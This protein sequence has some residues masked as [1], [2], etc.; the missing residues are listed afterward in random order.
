[1]LAGVNKARIVLARRKVAVAMFLEAGIDA[2]SIRQVRLLLD[3]K[4]MSRENYPLSDQ[5]WLEI[6]DRYE[7]K[8][9]L[10]R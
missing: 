9:Q 1:M 2:L 4:P 3:I 10:D 8:A 5:Q 6:H 7:H